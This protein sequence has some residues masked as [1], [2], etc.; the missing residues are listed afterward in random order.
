MLGAIIGDIVGSRFEWNN[1]K[2]KKFDFLTNKCFLTDDSVM[3]L[4]VAKAILDSNNK[5]ENLSTKVVQCMQEIG[6]PYPYCGYGGMFNSW[7]Y[8]DNPK[9]YKSYGNGAA[10]RVSACGFAGKSM[11]EVKSLSKKVTSVTHN[12]REGIKGA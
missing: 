9:P 3:S 7:M 4:A 11:D 6:R 2:S 8:S 5:Y 12:H 10:M 1:N